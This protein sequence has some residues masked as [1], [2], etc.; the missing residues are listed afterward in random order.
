MTFKPNKKFKKKY[1]KIFRKDPEAANLFLLLCE[2]AD[3]QGQVAT[4]EQ[5]IAELMDARFNDPT[6]YSL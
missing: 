4:N 1:D 5:E 2:I 3:D 6:E